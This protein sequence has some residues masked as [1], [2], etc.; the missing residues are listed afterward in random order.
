MRR[1]AESEKAQTRFG[2]NN[3]C[4]GEGCDHGD[5][6]NRI[7][8]HMAEQNITVSTAE[9][10]NRGDEIAFLDRQHLAAHDAA[11][12]DPAAKHERHN[13]IDHA[14]SQEGHDGYGD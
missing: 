5:A 14:L 8:Y 12:L 9:R 6:G 7:R 3:D 13:E 10:L 4:H 2:Y 11:I 1:H